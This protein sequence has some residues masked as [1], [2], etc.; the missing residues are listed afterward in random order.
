MAG[1]PKLDGDQGG[2]LTALRVTKAALAELDAVA[3]KTTDSN[4][5]AVIRRA[6]DEF[7]ERQK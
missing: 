2:T 3:E 5:S 4:R 6:I 7:L 1:L